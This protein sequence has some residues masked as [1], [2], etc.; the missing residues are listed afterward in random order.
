MTVPSI[1]PHARYA[2]PQLPLSRR[3]GIEKSPSSGSSSSAAAFA[4]TARSVSP[5]S[6][7]GIQSSG[8]AVP[9][10]LA[11]LFERLEGREALDLEFKAARDALPKSLWPTVSAF[12][13]TRGGYGELA[14][15]GIEVGA[16]VVV[17]AFGLLLLTGY[18]ASERLI[19]L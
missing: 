16:A 12:A 15:R 7:G 10:L 2:T 4:Q 5:W 11:T 1:R 9:S 6:L 3:N 18:M 13:N 19:G 14:M 8:S 17:V